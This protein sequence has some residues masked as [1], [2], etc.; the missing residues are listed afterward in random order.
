MA[1]ELP[2]AGP[3]TPPQSSPPTART[4]RLAGLGGRAR[5]AP[6]AA[7]A[8][9]A[10]AAVILYGI[11]APGS[12]PLTAQDVKDSI[13]SALASVTP[14][15]AYSQSVYQAVQPSLVLIQ[16]KGVAPKGA[17]NDEGGGLGSGVVVNQGGDILTSRHVIHGATSI[18]L[19]FAD[20]S[21]SPGEIVSEQPEL[22]I[23]VV[24]ATTP[25]ATLVP[26]TIGDP[27]A[28][29]PGSEAYAMGSP[30]GLYGSITTGV[31]SAL[32]RSFQ[33]P[34]GGPL[35]TGLFQID[36]AVNPGN[37][38]GALTDRDGRVIGIV[39]ALV[40]PTKEDVF[41]G[42]GLAVPIDVAGSAAGLPPY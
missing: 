11:L 15:P 17:G 5:W 6:F 2:P 41:I 13:A 14:P 9:V 27:R 16:T 30:F 24:H 39:T 40:N 1:W 37:S 10:L 20:G 35:L 42:I 36:A 18:E 33:M 34:D 19:T 21:K 8:A 25:P 31:I 26:A 32:D 4:A 29:Q 7:G 23:A 22:D 3:E 12:T 38:G 28:V